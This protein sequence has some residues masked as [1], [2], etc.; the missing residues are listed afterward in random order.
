[1]NFA[2][3][4][5]LCDQVAANI[6]AEWGPT[7]NDSVERVYQAPIAPSELK[8]LSGRKVYIFPSRKLNLGAADRGSDN[9]QWQIGV[10]AV[11]RYEEAGMPPKEW[12]DERTY[13]MEATVESAVDF[14]GREEDGVSNYL[15]FDGRTL[16]TQSIETEIYD[17]DYLD[18]ANLFWST[19]EVIYD[20]VTEV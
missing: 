20:E 5:A 12:M 18:E 17:V 1:M 10:L 7:G 15:E 13:W 19:M 2:Q 4:I 3:I 6:T 11:E 16:R 14:D 8:N 9:L